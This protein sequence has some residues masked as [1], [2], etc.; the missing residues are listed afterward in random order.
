MFVTL[1]QYLRAGQ[2]LTRIKQLTGSLLL[3]QAPS[4]RTQMLGSA[5]LITAVKSFMKQDPDGAQVSS[6]M[7]H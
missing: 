2:E 4:L 7:A 5:E 3:E 6:S 1:V